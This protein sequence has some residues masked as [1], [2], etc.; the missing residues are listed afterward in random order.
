MAGT[1]GKRSSVKFRIYTLLEAYEKRYTGTLFAREEIKQAINDI[2]Q[3]PLR[4]FAQ[5]S[6]RR[7]LKAGADHDTIVLMVIALH[8][9]D[10]LV[11][12]SDDEQPVQE[13]QIICSLG[14][15]A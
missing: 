13:P 12:R 6:I 3:F 14:L 7:Q 8:E 11:V 15:T 5:E 10:K 1:L 2:Y 4:E 9:D